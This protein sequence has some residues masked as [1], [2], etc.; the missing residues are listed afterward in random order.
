MGIQ[1]M[2]GGN[3]IGLNESPNPLKCNKKIVTFQS[4]K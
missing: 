4:Q 2:A 3:D 1:K